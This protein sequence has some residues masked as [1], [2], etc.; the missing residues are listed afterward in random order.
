MNFFEKA[1][2]QSER[3]PNAFLLA[4]QRMLLTRVYEIMH[5]LRFILGSHPRVKS[6][7]KEDDG[8]EID[9]ILIY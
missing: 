3:K 5:A 9:E 2:W 8:P 6:Q 7:V 4:D 1:Q